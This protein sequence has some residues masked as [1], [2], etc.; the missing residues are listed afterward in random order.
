M[1]RSTTSSVLDSGSIGVVI[2]SKTGPSSAS[3]KSAISAASPGSIG[4]VGAGR[5]DP[6]SFRRTAL[7]PFES[8]V[9]LAEYE[10]VT[11]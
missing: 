8:G 6:R 11:G 4:E 1:S 9:I 7:T 5:Y 10:R 3:W 2:G